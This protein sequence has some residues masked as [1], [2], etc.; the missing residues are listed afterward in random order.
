MVEAKETSCLLF[1]TI[2]TRVF[3]YDI[4]DIYRCG[5]NL[6]LNYIY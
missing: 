4:Y 5:L 3:F 2:I 6:N 1:A